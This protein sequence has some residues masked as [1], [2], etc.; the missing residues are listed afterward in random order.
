MMPGIQSGQRG[1]LEMR[2]PISSIFLW[3]MLSVFGWSQTPVGAIK[4]IAGPIAQNVS[5][6]QATIWWQTNQ[7]SATVVRY[8]LAPDRLT[9]T[10][11]QP[12]GDESHSVQLEQLKANTT[13]FFAMLR[14]SGEV[15]GT[16]RFTTQP[17]GFQQSQPVRIVNGPR[18]EFLGGDEAVISWSTNVPSSAVVRYGLNPASMSHTAEQPWGQ[19]AHRVT[20]SDL[21]QGETYYFA[22]ESGQT[23]DGSGAI[24]RSQPA[25][26]QTVGGSAAV[27]PEQ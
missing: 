8:G 2:A 11:Q 1:V 15:L 18:I 21:Q 5:D 4:V 9:D 12:W 27:P 14:G 19:T 16:G 13:Y 23:R 20:I 10:A 17:S 24:A 7:P 3:V 25:M 6:S 22:V 26:F